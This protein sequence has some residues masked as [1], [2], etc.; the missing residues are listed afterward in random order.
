MTKNPSDRELLKAELMTS[1]IIAQTITGR[2]G[3][4]NTWDSCDEE[5]RLE[6]RAEIA[7][8]IVTLL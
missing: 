6:I 8:I 1:A 7:S 2:S 3:F 4:G 5:V